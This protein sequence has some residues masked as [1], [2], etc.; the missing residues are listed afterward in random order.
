MLVALVGF[1][2]LCLCCPVAVVWLYVCVSLPW[3]AMSWS[4]VFLRMPWAGLWSSL[5]CHGLVCGLPQD[6]MGW[7]LVFDCGTSWSYSY[8]FLFVDDTS[9]PRSVTVF[10]FP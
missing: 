8:I 1:N 9:E 4:V 3:D 7:S 6:A 10:F 2:R 5:G